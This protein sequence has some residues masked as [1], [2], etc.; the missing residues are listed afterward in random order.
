MRCP[1]IGVG[2]WPLL[3]GQRLS[4]PHQPPL[5]LT[6]AALFFSSAA[7][8]C[9]SKPPLPGQR[10]AAPKGS[11]HGPGARRA[12][13]PGTVLLRPF[14][15]TAPVSKLDA[16]LGTLSAFE[17]LPDGP[18]SGPP[19]FFGHPPSSSTPT[20]APHLVEGFVSGAGGSGG[21]GHGGMMMGDMMMQLPRYV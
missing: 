18:G 15:A 4:P 1:H 12:A 2:H 7:G 14:L 21:H 5:S 19:I 13:P 11:G 16:P 9:P 10:D 6:F 17:L 20:A 3:R 8:T